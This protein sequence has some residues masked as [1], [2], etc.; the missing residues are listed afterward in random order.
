MSPRKP[1]KKYWSY[2]AGERPNTVL[3]FERTKGGVLY[4]KVW[5]ASIG[6]QTKL[7]LGHRD[8]EAA[9][10]YAEEEA[11]KLR[12]GAISLVAAPTIGYVTM[13]YLVH[14]TPKKK[15]SVQQA[16][17]RSVTMWRRFLG[18]GKR[19]GD[20]GPAEWDSFINMRSSGAIDS[21]GEPVKEGLNPLTNQPYRVPVEP[22]TVDADLVFMNAVLNWATTWKLN[23][24][25]LLKSN[26]WGGQAAGVKRALERPQTLDPKRPVAT[27]DRFLKVRAAAERI[28]ME[29][30]KGEAGAH[31]VEVGR[32]QYRHGEGPVNKWMKSS[33]LPELLDLVEDT[34]RRITAVCRLWYSDFIR[35]GGK[36]T[37]IRW[38]PIKGSKVQI[39][40][41]GE[42]AQAAI[43]RILE[44]RPGIGDRPVFPAAR[45]R[46]KQQKELPID[47]HLARDWLEKAEILAGVGHLDGGDWHP[48][49]RKWAIERKHHPT[50][51][52]MEGGGWEDERSLKT[53][54]QL[55]DRETVL[56]VMNEPRKLR[57]K[58]A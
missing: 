50:A 49:R 44:Q 7:S 39:V 57:E 34:G 10:K 28:L 53:S 37:Q 11:E 45:I 26:P 12:A 21:R 36:V 5:D 27:Y 15:P 48:Y 55:A 19:C 18:A 16:D 40:P 38:R 25:P 51:D 47:R 9:I 13:Q 6:D 35:E 22:R 4:A 2:S 41:I 29:V 56:A 32:A 20:L 8:R 46:D 24:R 33:Y 58:K 54:Y 43:A 14:R 42:R 1:K 17:R 52:V 3:V 30:R 31:L 23:G